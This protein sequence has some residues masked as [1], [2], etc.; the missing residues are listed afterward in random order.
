MAKYLPSQGGESNAGLPFEKDIGGMGQRRLAGIELIDEPSAAVN[1]IGERSDRKHLGGGTD[2][3]K[4]VATLQQSLAWPHLPDL[5]SEQHDVWLEGI[6]TLWAKRDRSSPEIF[7]NKKPREATTETVEMPVFA[8][9]FK[10]IDA[11]GLA[12]KAVDVLRDNAVESPGLLQM[13]KGEVSRTGHLAQE[14][15]AQG[16]IELPGLRWI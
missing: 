15:Y 11:A 12:V 7:L 6:I 3:Q 16:T 5:F 14:N 1:L 9:D 2:Y 4:Q 13:G 10:D 8:M